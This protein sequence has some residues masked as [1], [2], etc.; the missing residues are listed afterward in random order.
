MCDQLFAGLVHADHR[1]AWIVGLMIK[2]QHILH[3][4]DKVRVLGRWNYP[5]LFQLRF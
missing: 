2:V 4:E 5:L 1:T 3:A